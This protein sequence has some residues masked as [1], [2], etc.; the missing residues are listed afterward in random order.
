MINCTKIVICYL[1]IQITIKLITILNILKGH[2]NFNYFVH[3]ITIFNILKGWIIQNNLYTM[4]ISLDSRGAL[5]WLQ[6]RN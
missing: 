3:L 1:L 2:I 6:V 5:A 4:Q